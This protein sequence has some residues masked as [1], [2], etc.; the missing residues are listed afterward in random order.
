MIQPKTIFIAVHHLKLILD[1]IFRE[2]VWN[3]VIY[4]SYLYCPKV[5]RNTNHIHCLDHTQCVGEVDSTEICPFM[6][7]IYSCL[8]NISQ[9]FHQPSRKCLTETEKIPLIH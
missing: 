9:P 5:K 8:A 1:L 4:E 7:I 3:I 6:L 2:I